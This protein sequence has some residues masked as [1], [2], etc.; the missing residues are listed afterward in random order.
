MSLTRTFAFLIASTLTP[1]SVVGCFAQTSPDG[2]SFE[3]TEEALTTS[4][5]FESGSKTSYA[6]AN[7]HARLRFLEPER[8][9]VTAR[10]ASSRS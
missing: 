10:R 2:E 4:E 3:S 8:R 6:A 5:G 9:A 7:A 1:L